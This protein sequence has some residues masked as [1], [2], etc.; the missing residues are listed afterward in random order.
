MYAQVV[1]QSWSEAKT[2]IA[3]LPSFA[4]RGQGAATWGLETAIERA[5]SVGG[6][7]GNALPGRETWI[8]NQ[9]KRRAH[10]VMPLPQPASKLEW[11][12]AIQHYGGP[13][14]LLDFTRS[15]YI[16]AF[17]A[18]EMALGDAAV[19]AINLEHLHDVSGIPAAMHITQKQERCRDLAE[20]A[21]A[22]SPGLKGVIAVEPEFLNERIAVQQGLFLLPADLRLSFFDNLATSAPF[23]YVHDHNSP[24]SVR[25]LGDF[26]SNPHM[27]VA[28]V[29]KFVL[30]HTI[31]NEI[32]HDLARMNVETTSLF[33]GLDG[34][35]RSMRRHL[36]RP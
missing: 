22:H 36:R 14:R 33:P 20:Q 27:N 17:F 31:H 10:L 18:V 5:G 30:P 28:K 1:V 35:A 24:R 19:W 3:V 6:W 11:L 12:A 21:F 16:A 2:S 9:F 13:T 8:L 26:L 4:F 7:S 25:A 32:I 34:F 29:V 15:F 23:D